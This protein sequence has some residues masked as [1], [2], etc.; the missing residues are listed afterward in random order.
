VQRHFVVGAGSGLLLALVLS[1]C[2]ARTELL[3]PEVCREA[4]ETRPCDN[5]CGSGAQTCRDGIWSACEV[6]AVTR[7]CSNACGSGSESCRDGKWTA[8]DV[9]VA[10]RACA[11]ECGPGEDRCVR[12]AWQGCEVPEV[13]RPCMSVCGP[14]NEHCKNGKWGR[15]DAPQP[16]PPLLKGTVRDFSPNTHP[17]FEADYFP[18]V[19]TG[20]VAQE[21]GP[22]D[23]PVYTGVPGRSNSGK[24]NF[25]Q[26]FH[27]DPI[28]VRSSL[29][30]Q[31]KGSK[32]DPLL[33]VYDDHAFFPIDEQSFGNEG[34]PHNFHF[35]FEAGTIFQYVGGETFSFSGDD[36]MWVF[37]NRRL[38]IDLG[39]IHPSE[40]A[41]V[42]LDDIADNFGL[43]RGE[44]Y[45]L[46]FFFAERHTNQSNFTIRTSIAEP[47]SC[48]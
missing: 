21:L 33:F 13:L 30:L 9:P 4:G 10:V 39:G 35:T 16:K 31:L 24:A 7:A 43:V 44:I 11:D 40:S 25:D 47:G 28:S 48:Q 22:D 23:K 8:C 1:S 3:L 46:H 19:I 18:G 29:E 32:D 27:D 14:G 26:W 45:P 41:E 15:C 20:M 42:A 12:G 37:I 6:P 36:D 5:A 38:A 2:G 17:D 34:R